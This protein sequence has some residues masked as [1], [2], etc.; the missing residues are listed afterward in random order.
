MDVNFGLTADDYTK[1]RAGFPDTFFERVF[2]DGY[3]KA[4]DT[5]LDIGT[6][7]GTLARGFAMRGCHVTGTD[8]SAQMV[9]RAK[10]MRKQ[11]GLDVVFRVAPAEETGFPDSTFD[12]VTAG[13]CWHW[14]DRP[15]A[16]DEVKRIL[17][18][19]GTVIIAHFDWIPIT[20]NVVDLTEKLI[21]KHNPNWKYGGGTG[22][23]PEWL[24][25]L[26]ETGFENIVTFSFDVDAPYTA[27][28][29]RGRI[30][31]SA[32]VGASLSPEAVSRFDSQLKLLLEEKFQV[33]AGNARVEPGRNE[34]V[35][36]I[37]HRIFA[38][39]AHN[40]IE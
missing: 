18:P 5:L 10:E 13:Q 32:G 11:Q 23:Y 26:G 31:A 3:V 29:W 38:V 15:R 20:G 25:D 39:I 27:D 35:L 16:A 19:G 37:P 2:A 33:Q 30:R 4:G 14:I 9:E 36:P 7:T 34:A 8:Y 24:R 22:M 40:P 21:N 6:G 12:I 1:H 28:A 17:K